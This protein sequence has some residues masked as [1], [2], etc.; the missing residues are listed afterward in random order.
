[1]AIKKNKV[2]T[3]GLTGGIGSGKSTVSNYFSN[4]GTCVIDADIIARQLVTLD[5]PAYQA[6]VNHFGTAI[7][8]PDKTINRMALRE[9]IFS[10]PH[11]KKWLEN[12]LHPLIRETMQVQINNCKQDYCV[13]VIPLLAESKDIYFIDRVLLIESPVN[14]QRQRA[15]LRDQASSESIQK[16]ID[17]QATVEKRREIADDILQNDS[18]LESL[19]EKVLA[20]H[21]QYL[22]LAKNG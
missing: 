4:L 6:M 20:L 2:L 21:Q 3:I 14:T 7:Q 11:E 9:I 15:A 1:M 18:T 22:Y 5:Q 10:D 16:I 13:C 12:L 17:S 19:K 8:N